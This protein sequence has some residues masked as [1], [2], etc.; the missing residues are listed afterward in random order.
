MSNSTLHNWQ[1]AQS[2]SAAT[3]VGHYVRLEQLD[4]TRHGDDLWPALQ[5]PEADPQ[6]WQYLGY[7]PFAERAEFDRWLAS[8]A[9]HNDPLFYTVLDRASGKALGLLSYLSLAPQHGSIEI[10]HVCFGHAL[11][12]SVQATETIYLLAR[13]AFELGNR[14]L[15]WKCD[16]LNLRSRRAAERF[17]FSHEGVFRQHLVRKGR[18]RDTAWFSLLDHEW[19]ARQ[20]TFELWLAAENFDAQGQQRQSLT[21]LHAG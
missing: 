1:P 13:Y 18:N 14:R 2:P 21:A 9:A 19:P 12:R 3:L 4:P 5:G 7:G 11:Q 17:G 16:N 6:M 10:G 20:R 15:E 8:H